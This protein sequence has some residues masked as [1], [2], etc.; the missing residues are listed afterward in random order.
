M[1]PKEGDLRV[2]HIPNVPRDPYYVD[3]RSIEDAIIILDALAFYDLYLGENVIGTNVQGLMIFE[4][5]E[6]CEWQDSD[7]NEIDDLRDV[8]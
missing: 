5:G 2:Y 1:I 7:G 8:A 6:W 3:V 4:D